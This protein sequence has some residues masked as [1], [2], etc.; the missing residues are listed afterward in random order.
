MSHKVW[1]F[2]ALVLCSALCLAVKEN[3][4][5]SNYPMYGDPD[6]ISEY[7]HLADGEGKPLA[8]RSLTS[9]TCPQVGKILRKRGDDRGKELGM[10]R[11]QMP[12]E[13]WEKICRLTLA[14]LRDKAKV[15]GNT[16]PDKLKIMHTTIEFKE[17]R[18]VETPRV[19]F[20]E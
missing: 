12:P 8:V 6:P 15:F 5:F 16:L 10:K 17:G 2:I 19:F 13:E 4:P 11:K 14:E 20:A 7:Y 18:V 9:V 3:Y 1:V